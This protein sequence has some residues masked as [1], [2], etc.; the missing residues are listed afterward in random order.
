MQALANIDS[1][2]LCPKDGPVAGV[3]VLVDRT[4]GLNAIQAEQ[5][6]QLIDTWAQSVPSGGIFKVYEVGKAKDL[7][8]PIVTACNP[9]DG[10][11]ESYLTGNPAMLRK[12]YEEHYVDPIKKMAEGMRADAEADS[13]PIMEAVQAVT[14]QDF[15]PA[16]TKMMNKRLYIVSDLMQH[17]KEFS[18]YK[19]IPDTSAF[20]ATPYAASVHVNLSNIIVNLYAVTRPGMDGDKLGKLRQFWGEWL[21]YQG[22]L[23]LDD[24]R[25]A[26]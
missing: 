4:D 9:G 8:T 6:V 3:T 19:G 20:S 18:L 23:L 14:I 2:T 7:L 24:K 21:R 17:V 15:G 16:Q 10:S 11:N 13:S 5:V 25:I 26:G 22:G 12:Q 1:T